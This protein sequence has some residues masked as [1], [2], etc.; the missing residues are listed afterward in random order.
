MYVWTASGY[1]YLGRIRLPEF[2]SQPDICGK[3]ALSHRNVT[4]DCSPNVDYQQRVIKNLRAAQIDLSPVTS[5]DLLY[6]DVTS[7]VDYDFELTKA[8]RGFLLH[9]VSTRPYDI[10]VAKSSRTR[11]D[12]RHDS[13]AVVRLSATRRTTFVRVQP[14]IA[15]IDIEFTHISERLSFSIRIKARKTRWHATVYGVDIFS[16]LFVYPFTRNRVETKITVLH[17]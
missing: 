16:P 4:R 1:L 11:R 2:G 6:C 3:M 5:N 13:L 10:S 15:K 14:Q 8:S 17:Y 12:V 9:I 7:A